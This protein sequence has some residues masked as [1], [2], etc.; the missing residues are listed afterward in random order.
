MTLLVADTE[1][2][3]SFSCSEVKTKLVKSMPLLLIMSDIEG[4]FERS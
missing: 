2:K 4:Y 3:I 1:Y